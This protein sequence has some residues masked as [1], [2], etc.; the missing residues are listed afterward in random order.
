MTRAKRGHI[1]IGGERYYITPDGQGEKVLPADVEQHLDVQAP[2]PDDIVPGIVPEFSV[3][4][5]RPR[6]R[7]NRCGFPGC[8]RP[9][10]VR[11][12]SDDHAKKFHQLAYRRRRRGFDRWLTVSGTVP[13]RFHRPFPRS[14]AT[15]KK[16]LAEHIALAVCQYAG[17]DGYCPGRYNPYGDPSLPRCLIYQTYADDYLIWKGRHEGKQVKRRYTTPDGEWE[18]WMY[19]AEQWEQAVSPMRQTTGAQA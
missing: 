6:A 11:F 18:E 4:W 1:D 9:A 19:D 7:R 16:L 3:A 15:A 13:V 14:M 5:L 8:T 17:E 12:C 2:R 10:R